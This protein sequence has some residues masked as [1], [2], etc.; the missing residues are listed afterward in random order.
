MGR[1]GLRRFL[2]PLLHCPVPGIAPTGPF[3][4]RVSIDL[5]SMAA[6]MEVK[7]AFGGF[8]S[9]ATAQARPRHRAQVTAVLPPMAAC[10][11]PRRR[12]RASLVLA[13][14]GELRLHQMC[15]RL[16]PQ[17]AGLVDGDAGGLQPA[18]GHADGGV[19]DPAL[20]RVIRL[21]AVR[22][23]PGACC[24]LLLHLVEVQAV[25]QPQARAAEL[26]RGRVALLALGLAQALRL[27]VPG[28]APGAVCLLAQRFLAAK[29]A[30]DAQ[31]LVIHGAARLVGA[32]A[33][34]LQPLMLRLCVLR[35]QDRELDQAALLGLEDFLVGELLVL[36]RATLET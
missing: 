2:T 24:L 22:A 15:H 28:A 8:L 4:G 13:V 23:H 35:A 12:T 7:P 26:P 30:R 21:V 1:S 29:V 25:S 14:L 9:N 16:K 27:W 6:V 17:L 36:G 33:D 19:A 31:S 5:C 11:A 18:A 20:L 32:G 10:E 34:G 3:R